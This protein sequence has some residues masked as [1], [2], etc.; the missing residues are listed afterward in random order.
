MRESRQL[1]H[2][3]PMFGITSWDGLRVQETRTS[4]VGTTVAPKRAGR[5]LA[6]WGSPPYRL[7]DILMQRAEV[8]ASP[9]TVRPISP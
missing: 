6:G 4:R 8:A 2:D 3:F 1:L 7:D 9:K 5:C